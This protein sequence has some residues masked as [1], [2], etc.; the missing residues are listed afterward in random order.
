MFDPAYPFTLDRDIW[1]A[2]HPR[3]SK[4]AG[5]IHGGTVLV[6]RDAAQVPLAQAVPLPILGDLV[7]TPSG[8]G[9]FLG[10]SETDRADGWLTAWIAPTSWSLATEISRP[11]ERWDARRCVLVDGPAPA[12]HELLR[13]LADTLGGYT[14]ARRL[15]LSGPAA[16]DATTVHVYDDLGE[17]EGRMPARRRIPADAVLDGV[18]LSDLAAPTRDPGESEEVAA[19]RDDNDERADRALGAVRAYAAETYFG[20]PGESVRTILGDFLGD[21]RHACDALGLAWPDV[22]HAG[23]V[24]YRAELHGEP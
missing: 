3:P 22:E 21:L 24:H 16:G 11:V 15:L 10:W 8:R 14:N 12:Q 17:P 7:S 19:V 13:L 5:L 23:A 6:T 18:F 1:C 20:D 2:D 9:W 4:V